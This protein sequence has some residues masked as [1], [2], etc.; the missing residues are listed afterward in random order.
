[1][2]VTT[3]ID[4]TTARITLHGDIDHD[5][6]PTIRAAAAELPPNTTDLIWDLRYTP[7]MDTAG[8]H[9]FTDPDPDAGPERRTTLFGLQPQPLELIRTAADLFPMCEFA[10]LLPEAGR[11]EAA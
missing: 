5:T 9:L 2:N 1:M 6:L 8:L 11:R 10:C 7:F 4:G 3:M